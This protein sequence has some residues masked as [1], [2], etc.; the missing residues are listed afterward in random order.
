MTD[1]LPIDEI[2]GDSVVVASIESK[3]PKRLSW[4]RFKRDRFAIAGLGVVV[5]FLFIAIFAPLITKILGI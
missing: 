1:V 3:S 2:D 4:D 5:F